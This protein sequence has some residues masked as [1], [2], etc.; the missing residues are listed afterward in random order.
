METREVGEGMITRDLYCR[1]PEKSKCRR[2][3]L[4]VPNGLTTLGN[5]FLFCFISLFQMR[6]GT[7]DNRAQRIIDHNGNNGHGLDTI[8][9]THIPLAALQQFLAFCSFLTSIFIPASNRYLS[10][11]HI[12]TILVY[13]QPLARLSF[14]GLGWHYSRFFTSLMPPSL[15]CLSLAACCSSSRPH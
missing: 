11:F 14:H 10:L 15:I 3:V 4:A 5:R 1:L 6:L 13:L 12:H 7:I 8:T 9:N 2:L